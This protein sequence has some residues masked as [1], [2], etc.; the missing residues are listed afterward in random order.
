MYSGRVQRSGLCGGCRIEFAWCHVQSWAV[1]LV[2]WIFKLCSQ[3]VNYLIL[4]LY[5]KWDPLSYISHIEVETL[6]NT[7]KEGGAGGKFNAWSYIFVPM[8]FV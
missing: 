7:E 2:V 6:K 1:E 8:L 5:W 4:L 3:S